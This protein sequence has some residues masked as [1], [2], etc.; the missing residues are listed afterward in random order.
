M[1]DDFINQLGGG[2]GEPPPGGG[3]GGGTNAGSTAD[4]FRNQVLSGLL[5]AIQ[6]AFP[7][8]TTTISGAATAGAATLP[9]NPTAFL[10]ITVGSDAYKVPLYKV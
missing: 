5:T 6:A 1:P 7:Q 10:T 9:A 4:I 3:G 2:G 8:A